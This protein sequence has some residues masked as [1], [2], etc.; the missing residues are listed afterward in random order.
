MRKICFIA[1]IPKTIEWF[2]LDYA[3]YLAN[4]NYDVYV[5]C[6][7][8][9]SFNEKLSKKVTYLPIEMKRGIDFFAF[10][11]IINFIKIFKQYN[12]DMIQY[13]TPN[14]SLYAS[15]AGFLTKIPHRIYRQWGMVYVGFSGVKHYIFK[16][17][18]K[19]ICRFSNFVIP[20]SFGNLEFGRRN[21]LYTSEKS[22]VI[23]NGSAAGIDFSKFNLSK[24]SEWRNEIRSEFDINNNDFVFGFV[25]RI[26]RDKGINELLASFKILNENYPTKL[27]LVGLSDREYEIDPKLLEWAKNSSDVFFT[28]VTSNTE[29]YYSAFDVFILPSY[30]EGFGSTIIEAE[31]MKIPVITTNIPGPSEAI[32]NNE[33]GYL[34]SPKDTEELTCAMLKLYKNP[35]L[36]EEMGESGYEFAKSKFDRN[37]LFD[38]NLIFIKKIFNEQ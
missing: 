38:A 10:K 3:E 8:D 29:K 4:N 25:G 19:F 34:I 35:K 21:L 26:N 6:N 18:E 23:H 37:D 7:S 31:A 24:K 15:F 2:M 27:F 12:F 32:I 36:C 20:D 9:D 33:T 17:I 16:I 22:L 14:A 13:T 28:G 30:R 5:I 1:T 11:S